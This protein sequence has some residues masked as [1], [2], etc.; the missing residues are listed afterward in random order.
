M[1]LETK[2]LIPLIIKRLEKLESEIY[3]ISIDFENND[4]VSEVIDEME[5]D[6]LDIKE[7]L[8]ELESEVESGQAEEGELDELLDQSDLLIDNLSHTLKV[9]TLTLDEGIDPQSLKQWKRNLIEQDLYS[10]MAEYSFNYMQKILHGAM[11]KYDDTVQEELDS[12]VKTTAL[13]AD[14][15]MELEK[16][17]LPGK[18]MPPLPGVNQ[19]F[20]PPIA[21]ASL[22][23]DLIKISDSLD[24]LGLHKESDLVDAIIKKI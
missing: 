9:L 2:E 1:D 24:K 20:K 15:R 23:Q 11:D 12:V 18:N 13:P 17:N 14:E 10:K 3:K 19:H 6:I 5:I 8:L 21:E 22:V 7:D 4:F 16:I